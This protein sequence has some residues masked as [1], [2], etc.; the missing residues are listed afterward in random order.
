MHVPFSLYMHASGEDDHLSLCAMCS[1]NH[2]AVRWNRSDSVKQIEVKYTCENAT[3]QVC[4]MMDYLYLMCSSNYAI[5]EN[6]ERQLCSKHA[7]IKV[8]H[9]TCTKQKQQL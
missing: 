4:E 5:K 2:A 7:L 3:T 1:D 9:S 6:I 8:L